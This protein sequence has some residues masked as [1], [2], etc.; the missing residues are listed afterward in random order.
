[1][2]RKLTQEEFLKK[3]ESRILELN[4]SLRTYYATV[5]SGATEPVSLL[6]TSCGKVTDILPNTLFHSKKRINGCKACA[7]KTDADAKKYSVEEIL[8][9]FYQAH[10]SK[11]TYPNISD[12]Y[13]NNK[14]RITVVCPTHGRFIQQAA[15]HT[16]SRY[17]CNKC[18]ITVSAL[19]QG[20]FLEKSKEVHGD[21]YDYS[22]TIY[23]NRNHSSED[24]K[25]E[26]VCR[27]HGIFVQRSS[28]HLN[29]HGCPQ[30]I[31]VSH[32][33]KSI[34]WLED[35]SRSSGRFI[36]HA[37]N[38]GEYHIPGTKLKADG[39]CKETNTIYEFY[40]DAFHGNI[41]RYPADHMPH[42]F[43]K[44]TCMELYIKTKEREAKLVAMGY[45]V[46]SIWES[47]YEKLV[48]EK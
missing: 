9:A 26:I 10:G 38:I 44:K 12:E 30:C 1:M 32:S 31:P 36:Q 27:K 23:K 25:I 39:W 45:T 48:N 16:R 28:D 43:N 14:S 46:V 37:E 19:K 35:I 5:Y 8:S 24:C 2:P 20:Q 17:G 13:I 42:P 15:T 40:G 11:F 29:G 18:A 21:R 34:Q 33:R 6:C 41:D 47:D 4:L 7:R 22:K 3:C